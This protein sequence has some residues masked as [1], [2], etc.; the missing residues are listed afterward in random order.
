MVMFFHLG[1]EDRFW[2]C[3]DIHFQVM[4]DIPQPGTHQ[5]LS[6]DWLIKLTNNQPKNGFRT[7]SSMLKLHKSQC[8]RTK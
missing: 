3:F 2:I 6:K 8:K 1:L 7:L 4:I 5:I